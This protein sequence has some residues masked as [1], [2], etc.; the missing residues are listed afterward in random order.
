M[1]PYAVAVCQEDWQRDRGAPCTT[2]SAAI[3]FKY[4][5]YSTLL[6]RS[7]HRSCVRISSYHATKSLVGKTLANRSSIC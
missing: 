2:E 3:Y 1:I 6:G 7:V 4:Q 5:L